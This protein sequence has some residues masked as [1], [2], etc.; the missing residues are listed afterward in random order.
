VLIL[1]GVLNKSE[2]LTWCFCGEV[3][4]DCVAVVVRRRHVAWSLKH[5][6]NL[7]FILR[8]VWKSREGNSILGM[9][10]PKDPEASI[11]CDDSWAVLAIVEMV[12]GRRKDDCRACMDDWHWFHC[13]FHD[14]IFYRD[15]NG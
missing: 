8:R 3:M 13:T 5:A 15:A 1:R 4:V 10:P 11:L 2:L 6:T 9:V 7:R 12:C 14:A